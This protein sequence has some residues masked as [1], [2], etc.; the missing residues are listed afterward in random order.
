MVQNWERDVPRFYP[1]TL[2]I[3]VEKMKST[4]RKNGIK[5]VG[6]NINNFRHADDIT[7]RLEVRFKVSLVKVKNSVKAC[8]IF[9]TIKKKVNSQ[10][11][12]VIAGGADDD[13][14]HKNGL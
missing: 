8:L 13:T 6:R 2:F 9:L 7:C 12:P 11:Q 3:Y 5:T 1:I 4:K 10:C 14:F